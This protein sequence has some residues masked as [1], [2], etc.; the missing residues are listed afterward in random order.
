VGVAAADGKAQASSLYNLC[1]YA[2]SSVV[3]WFG[4]VAFDA[5]GWPAV[6]GTVIGLAVVSGALAMTLRASSVPEPR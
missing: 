2:G 3:G 4:G 5:A 6:A 1:Y